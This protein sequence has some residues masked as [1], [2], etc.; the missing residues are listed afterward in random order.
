MKNK[1]Y[2]STNK[3]AW[4]EWADIHIKGS[5][6]YPV[7]QF[8]AG[9][10]GWTPNIPDDIGSVKGKSVLHLLC[11][12]G[13]DTLMWAG[14]GA[15]I[16]GVDFSENAISHARALSE[17][18]DINADFIHSDIYL[19]PEVLDRQFDIVLTYYGTIMWLPDLTKWAKVIAHFLKPGGFFYIAD[20]H[21]FVNMLNVE[22]NSNKLQ[23]VYSYFTSGEPERIESETGTYANPEAKTTHK[24]TFQWDHSMANII[25]AIT[26]SGL[27]IEYLHEFPYSF[28]DIFYF[29]KKNFMICDAQGWWRLKEEDV[30]LP[31]M[32]SVKA[33]KQK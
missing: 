11:H 7:E 32:F 15:R 4:D 5:S 31:L 19:L 26:N 9:Q 14:Q 10:Q 28:Y 29:A 23:I 2:L 16:T 13:M 33:L 20:V 17:E 21:P 8:K 1:D 24:V 6:F 25:N 22:K 18:L 30:K 12:F 27:R 3:K